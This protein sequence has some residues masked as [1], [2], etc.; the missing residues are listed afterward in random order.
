[1]P[2]RA[3]KA[4]SGSNERLAPYSLAAEMAERGLF[5]AQEYLSLNGDG[6]SKEKSTHERPAYCTCLS[7]DRLGRMLVKGR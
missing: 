5:R 1:M 3:A 6:F 7:T 4:I 2:S